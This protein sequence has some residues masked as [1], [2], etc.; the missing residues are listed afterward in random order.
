MKYLVEPR[1]GIWV[2]VNDKLVEGKS[3]DTLVRD[4]IEKVGNID[5]WFIDLDDN[6]APSPA[7]KLAYGRVGT[8]IFSPKFIWWALSQGA[9]AK[10]DKNRESVA[11]NAYVENF[12]RSDEA[13]AEVARLYNERS[14]RD[15]LYEGVQ[16]FVESLH[17]R[18]RF[19]VTRN[20]AEV[21]EAY[22]EALCIEG[23]FSEADEKGKVVD[24]YLRAHP[25]VR[26]IGVE[27]DSKEDV[28]MIC[29]AEELGVN[30]VSIYSMNK[31]N[32]SKIDQ[33]F[34]YFVS[35]DRSGLVN[36]LQGY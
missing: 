13:L 23:T 12:L 11:W 33:R 21:A 4:L 5:A 25:D 15:S 28:Q 10:F 9:R 27:G 17:G 35:K 8:S 7:K 22:K 19:I 14:A 20:I 6:I 16:S 34:D 26:M 3:R 18:D 24:R 32:V 29:A 31:P 36:L 30:V 1:N 2:G